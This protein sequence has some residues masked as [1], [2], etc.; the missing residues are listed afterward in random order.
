MSFLQGL[1]DR[2]GGYTWLGGAYNSGSGTLFQGTI[3]ANSV[4]FGEP[5]NHLSSHSC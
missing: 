1:R 2:F 4:I 5:E 3:N